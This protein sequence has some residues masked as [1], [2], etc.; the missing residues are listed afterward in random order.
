[1]SE[2]EP[3]KMSPKT[4]KLLYLFLGAAFLLIAAGMALRNLSW[5]ENRRGIREGRPRGCRRAL[6]HHRPRP[7]KTIGSGLSLYFSSAQSHKVRHRP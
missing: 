1:M 5:G 6:L 4:K 7:V 2:N 3:K